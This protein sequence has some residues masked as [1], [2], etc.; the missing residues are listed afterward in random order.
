MDG[1]NKEHSICCDKFQTDSTVVA[2]KADGVKGDPGDQGEPGPP[3]P[4]VGASE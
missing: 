1:N 4:K 3:G 2:L